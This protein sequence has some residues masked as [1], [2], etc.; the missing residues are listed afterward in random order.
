MTRT[1]ITSIVC[2]IDNGCDD[3]DNEIIVKD[4]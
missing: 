1:I 2:S 3:D 4:E